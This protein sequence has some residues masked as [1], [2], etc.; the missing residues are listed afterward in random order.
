MKPKQPNVIVIVADDLGYGDIAAFGNSIV[1]TPN[2]DRM[3]AE[4]VT[5]TQHYSA[6]PICAPA[7]A[8]LLTGRYN[9]R[10]GAVDVPSNRG[11]DRIAL[12]ETTI[13]DLFRSAGYATGMVGKWHNGAHDMR[14][15]PNARGFDEFAGFL[16]GGMDYWQWVLDYNGTPRPSDCRYLTDVF[17]Q[18]AVEF[19]RRHRK[20]PFFL[21]LAYNAPH[22]PLQAPEELVERYRRTGE[23]TIAVSAIYAMIERMDAGIGQLNE[24]LESLGLLDDTLVL[25]TSDN[26]PAMGGTGDDCADRYNGPFSGNKYDVLEGGI[27]VPA[28]V[29]W[30]SGL[31]SGTCCDSLVHF[32][33]WLPTLYGLTGGEAP[34][35][36]SLDGDN[37]ISLLRGDRDADAIRARYWQWNRYEPVAHANAAMREG[38]WKLYWPP[39]PE[40]AEKDPADNVPYERFMLEAHAVM[41]IDTT[42]P[43]RSVPPPGAPR[44]FDLEA[45]LAEQTDL[46]GA[47]PERVGEMRQKWDAWYEG[48]M[49]D[50]RRASP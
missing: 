47:H 8:S 25:F 13:A 30:P 7:R 5:L 48:V 40:A 6:S 32:T 42:R 43:P 37:V 34:D 49:A 1:Q 17:S 10:T 9:H 3:A 23:L 29:R 27:R 20:E 35:G 28:I 16:N 15:H 46:S 18:E 14:Y 50:W 39:I 44:L 2:L 45:D 11:L 31:R 33:D 38:R 26:G 24:A 36:L 12:S 19:V 22:A 4:G 41:D 21:Y